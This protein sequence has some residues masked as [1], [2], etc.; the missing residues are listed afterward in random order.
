MLIFGSLHAHF[1]SNS[2]S[3]IIHIKYSSYSSNFDKKLLTVVGVP[4]RRVVTSVV[5]GGVAPPS[6]SQVMLGGG[7]P[8]ARQDSI[9]SF[10]SRARTMGEGWERM[11]ECAA[12]TLRNG[13]RQQVYTNIVRRW[14][15][16]SAPHLDYWSC[17]HTLI[18]SSYS[19][20]YPVFEL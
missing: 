2:L 12:R 10:H 6:F 17:T 4:L 5:V 19:Y 7:T 11:R 8:P 20:E 13:K 1:K 18:M 15:I 3:I 9:T 16:A 14:C